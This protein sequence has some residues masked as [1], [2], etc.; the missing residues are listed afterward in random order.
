M[1]WLPEL[2][3]ESQENFFGK[4]GLSWHITVICENISANPPRQTSKKSSSED[5]DSDNSSE[6]EE[7]HNF[8]TKIYS[9]K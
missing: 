4:R 9:N 3:M 6:S 2:F 8:S 1:K 7:E 5:D